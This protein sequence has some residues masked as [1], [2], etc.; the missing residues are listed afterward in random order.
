MISFVREGASSPSQGSACALLAF[1]RSFLLLGRLSLRFSDSAM[2]ASL[3]GVGCSGVCSTGSLSSASAS[4]T[5]VGVSSSSQLKRLDF[6]DFFLSFLFFGSAMSEPRGSS[7]S[8]ISLLPVD[9]VGSA[10]PVDA[11]RSLYVV[12]AVFSRIS[13]L[14]SDAST[15]GSSPGVG[16]ESSFQLKALSFL[17]FFLPFLFL[18][19]G[20]CGSCES[21]TSEMSLWPSGGEDSVGPGV[22]KDSPPTLSAAVVG[23]FPL[24]V[25]APGLRSYPG[26]LV[27][28]SP[29]LKALPFLDF[30][31][32]FLVLVCGISCS[33]GS[34]TSDMSLLS[35]DGVDSLGPVGSTTLSGKVSRAL[36]GKDVLESL[37]FCSIS[38]DE[39]MVVKSGLMSSWRSLAGKERDCFLL[40]LSFFDFLP[41]RLSAIPVFSS[42][43]NGGSTSTGGA[44]DCVESVYPVSSKKRSLFLA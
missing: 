5:G 12:S 9:G 30:L 13:S 20:I 40:F 19:T 27:A 18:G 37:A 1:F 24:G 21:T 36:V 33:L 8:E 25:P 10:A 22:S 44:D 43:A 31:F 29:Q 4:S 3:G 15:V 6:L 7:A 42:R 26:S 41:E 38:C 23:A 32:S 34:S 28:S 39:S 14:N 17:D 16:A 2:I 35:A 11:G